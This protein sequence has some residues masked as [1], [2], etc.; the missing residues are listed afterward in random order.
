VLVYLPAPVNPRLETTLM[1]EKQIDLAALER[2]VGKAPPRFAGGDLRNL[3]RLRWWNRS[4]QALGSLM[5][6]HDCPQFSIA[7]RQSTSETSRKRGGL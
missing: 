3:A 5:S 6:L 2:V 4:V 1:A 7:K